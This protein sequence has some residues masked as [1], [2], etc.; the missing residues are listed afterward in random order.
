MRKPRGDRT[1]ADMHEHTGDRQTHEH[2]QAHEHGAHDDPALA[3]LLDLDGEALRGYWA[4]AL[5]WVRAAASTTARRRI[6]DLGAGTGVGT[7]GLA[8]RFRDAEVV[9]VDASADMLRRVCAKALDLGLAGRVRTVRADLDEGWPELEPLDVAWASMSLHHMADPDR[10]L[11]ELFTALCPGGVLAVAEFSDPLR[12]LPDEL[13]IG[14]P[15]LEQ[16]CLDL[17]RAEHAAALPALGSDWSARLAAAGFD[18]ADERVFSIEIE[19]PPS[20]AAARYAQLSVR[21]LCEGAADRL[22]EQDRDTV[23]RLLDAGGPDFVAR[24]PD[25]RIRGV[26]TVTLARRP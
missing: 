14:R 7:I 23:A 9:A 19:P 24:R 2:G 8:Q 17:R 4:E 20:R 5:A 26:R 1:L 18:I 21:R 15:G 12:F 6:L 11:S 16:R 25:L 22:D 13:G 10:V 3:D